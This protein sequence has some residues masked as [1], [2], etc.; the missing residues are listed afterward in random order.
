MRLL[1]QTTVPPKKKTKNKKQKYISWETIGERKLFFFWA[2]VLPCCPGWS[3]TPRLLSHSTGLGFWKWFSFALP[4]LGSLTSGSVIRLKSQI[5]KRKTKKST[6]GSR[7]GGRR[8]LQHKLIQ[9]LSNKQ[10]TCR[11]D[12]RKSLWAPRGSKLW[13]GRYRGKREDKVT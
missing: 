7:Q 11:E 4:L 13:E 1:V 10:L 2:R 3:W 6:Q 8:W 12:K 9:H 5:I